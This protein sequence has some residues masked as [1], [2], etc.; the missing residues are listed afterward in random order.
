MSCEDVQPSASRSMCQE[1]PPPPVGL[2]NQVVDKTGFPGRFLVVSFQVGPRTIAP[3]P[4][5]PAKNRA[6][7]FCFTL[8]RVLMAPQDGWKTCPPAV[9]IWPALS[10]FGHR[11]PFLAT[12]GQVWPT[13]SS[14]RPAGG[15]QT[16]F[17]GSTLGIKVRKIHIHFAKIDLPGVAIGLLR[18]RRTSRFRDA[19]QR[20]FGICLINYSYLLMS[21]GFG[22]L[23]GPGMRISAFGKHPRVVCRARVPSIQYARHGVLIRQAGRVGREFRIT[24]F[25]PNILRPNSCLARRYW[26]AANLPSINC[27]QWAD[28]QIDD[29]IHE[30]QVRGLLLPVPET[31]I[32]QRTDCSRLTSRRLLHHSA[33]RATRQ[34]LWVP[35]LVAG[36]GE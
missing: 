14:F 21:G 2:V 26:S 15:S 16:L 31:L 4:R 27:K 30:R 5:K 17:S 1:R 24:S 22:S 6:R 8:R 9:Q 36:R 32:G 13:L 33:D 35:K 11:C 19:L 20:T 7:V 23:G 28:I 3:E 25:N 34:G 29:A 10:R 12:F 18:R